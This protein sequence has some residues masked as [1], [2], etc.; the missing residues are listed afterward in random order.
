[1]NKEIGRG[2]LVGQQGPGS[3]YVDTD[4]S[5]Y[6]VSAADK[7]YDKT[8]KNS[9]IEKDDFEIRDA[10]LEK[11]LKVSRFLEVPDYRTTFNRNK[12]KNTALSIPIVRFPLLEYCQECGT[13]R[14][15]KPGFINRRRTC[16]YCEK[17][18]NF[19]QFPIVVICKFGHI[20][21]FPYKRYIHINSESNASCTRQW[22]DKTG[23]SILN[24]TLRCN[25]GAS[26]SLNGVTGKTSDT[27]GSPYVNEMKG[28]RCFGEMP[29][30]GS[31]IKD[32]ECTETPIAVLKNSLNVY[33]PDT[34]EAL[35]IADNE[36]NNE[37]SFEEL[38]HEEF[39]FLTGAEESTDKDKLDVGVSF[40]LNNERKVIKSVNYV[41]RLQQ[42]IVQ[43]NFH[44]EEHIEE[45]E[46]F[47]RAQEGTQTSNLFSP[48]YAI[49]NWYPAKKVYG[50]GVFI[51][52]NSEIIE[53]WEK[54]EEVVNHYNK[55]K[56]RVGDFYLVEKFNSASSILIHTLA[57]AL[58]QELSKVSGYPI[59][60]IKER[61]YLSDKERGML[62][63][64]TDTDKDGT[65]GG[66]VR[67]AKR[68]TFHTILSSALNNME[69]C[70]SDP[71]CF[72]LGN[73]FGQGVHN[74]NGS[75]C[76][77]CSFLPST[78]C[79]YRNCFLDRDYLSRIQSSVKIT[80]WY[81]II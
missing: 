77:N 8:V 39:V 3:I 79:R 9:Y 33:R 14:K 71:V 20:S 18:Q 7:W 69:W 67:L 34:V 74:S 13:F 35:S 51:E 15:A 22:I 28:A 70:S 11:V 10:R 53:E 60:A 68:E 5:S 55:L 21:D 64:V 30:T 50:E 81:D 54:K 80:K 31:S 17:K 40:D 32:E 78:S 75:S 59:T 26:H 62:L 29:W 47:N 16:F 66:L 6:L 36:K 72:E 61:L 76:H 12:I 19:I 45:V 58:I 25:C 56:K 41:R 1:M 23:P 24:W 63:Y 49:R 57:H 65:Y 46:S 48:E 73:T 52:F 27:K 44:R 43:T 42:I 4:G 38:L 2:K 37:I